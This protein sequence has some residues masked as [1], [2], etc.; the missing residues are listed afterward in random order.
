MSALFGVEACGSRSLS[1]IPLGASISLSAPYMAS[2]VQAALL[3]PPFLLPH[4][5]AGTPGQTAPS[6]PSLLPAQGLQPG[7]SEF[8][9]S[10][11]TR[12]AWT[13]VVRE[14]PGGTVA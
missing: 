11:V 9:R 7:R 1:V 6:F 2:G 3:H 4:R 8:I 14:M 5:A 12:L 10:L 13:P